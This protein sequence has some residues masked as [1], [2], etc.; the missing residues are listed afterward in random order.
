MKLRAGR[1]FLH[2]TLDITREDSGGEEALAQ[3]LQQERDAFRLE[4]RPICGSGWA[5][6]SGSAACGCTAGR[7][8]GASGNKE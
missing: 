4:T 5:C 7:A 3:M 8:A 6:C 1:S 2:T